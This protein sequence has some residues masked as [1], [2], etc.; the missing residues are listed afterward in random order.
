MNVG[1]WV[2]LCVMKHVMVMI[3]TGP[4]CVVTDIWYHSLPRYRTVTLS[5]M[6]NT[7]KQSNSLLASQN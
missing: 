3:V 6:T 7:I 4:V 1:G 5:I 2:A